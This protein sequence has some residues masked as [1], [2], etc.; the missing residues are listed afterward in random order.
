MSQ[1][2]GPLSLFVRKIGFQCHSLV[3]KIPSEVAAGREAMLSA[4]LEENPGCAEHATVGQQVHC[5][6][7]A[8]HGTHAPSSDVHTLSLLGMQAN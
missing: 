8:P 2:L 1:S 4:C 6:V 7:Q 5:S 3:R